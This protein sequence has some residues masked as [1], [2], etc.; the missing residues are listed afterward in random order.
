MKFNS[1]PL[2]L[3]SERFILTVKVDA[4]VNIFD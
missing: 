2:P 4:V 3:L 1:S